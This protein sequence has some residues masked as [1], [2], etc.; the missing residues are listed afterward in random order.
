M[1]SA[2]RLNARLDEALAKKLEYLRKKTQKSTT[3]VVRRSI[4][5]YY[6]SVASGSDDPAQ[7]LEQTG[8]IGCAEGSAKLS[9]RYK[10]ELG[11]SLANKS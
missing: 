2:A 8:F 10:S 9:E 4:E 11:R 5:L 7:L 6:E 1:T 3:D